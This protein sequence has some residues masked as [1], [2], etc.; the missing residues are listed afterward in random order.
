MAVRVAINGFG[1]T[2]R[3][4]FRAAPSASSTSSGP[5]STTCW[6]RHARASP[7][8]RH[9]L[10]AF[11]GTVEVATAASSS[12]VARSPRHEADP[13]ALPWA[14]SASTSSSSPPG[15]PRARAGREAPRRRGPQGHHLRARQG[16][17]RRHRRSRRQL[18]RGLRPGA[19]RHLQRLVHDELPRT[20]G[21]GAARGPGD[22]PRLHDHRP[23]VHRRP[24]PARLPAQG[25]ASRSRRRAQHGPHHDGRREALGLVI[26]ELAG[27][28]HGYAVRVP[29]PT[30][31]LVDLTVEVE[32]PTT[33]TEVNE[34]F[35]GAPTS[36]G[37]R[38]S[39]LHRGPA[40]LDR[41]RR[42]RRT[43][44]SSTVR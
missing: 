1:R 19:E 26:P 13:G 9:G 11:P 30:G 21:Q 27:K 42:A 39:C 12:T 28:L 17:R 10:R 43:R 44:P 37:S 18:R 3:A 31:S 20:G 29:T 23:R 32:Q 35:A 38:A 6:I 2:G 33:A 36:T 8:P 16:R 4:A 14:E 7:A 15:A 40:R 25:P 34:L 22:P 41:H 5:L 24:A